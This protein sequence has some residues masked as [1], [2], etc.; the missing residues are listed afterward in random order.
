MP[1]LTT[2]D[3]KWLGL[4]YQHLTNKEIALHFGVSER[5]ISNYRKKMDLSKQSARTRNIK[6]CLQQAV[7]NEHADVTFVEDNITQIFR[8]LGEDEVNVVQ[9]QKK[10]EIHQFTV[11]L[12]RWNG[13][14]GEDEG[15]K[16][17]AAYSRKLVRVAIQKL[18][19]ENIA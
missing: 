7:A 10:K 3:K 1:K 18:K 14:E 11:M 2:E 9:L 13:D 5:T 6:R 16:I 17:L 19:I 12:S 8:D 4:N 15:F